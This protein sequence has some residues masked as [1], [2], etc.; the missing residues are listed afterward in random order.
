[1]PIYLGDTRIDSLKMG[2]QNISAGYL[3][4]IQVF[5]ADAPAPPPTGDPSDLAGLLR[6]WDAGTGVTLSTSPADRVDQWDDQSGN[7]GHMTPISFNN[8]RPTWHTNQINGLPALRFLRSDQRRLTF[9]NLGSQ[10]AAEAFIV[11]KVDLDPPTDASASALWDIQAQVGSG[12]D[13]HY[14]FTDSNVYDTFGTTARKS[15]GNPATNLAGWHLYNVRTAS[16]AW[17][18]HINGTQH[19]T[20]ATNTVGFGTAAHYLG[21]SKNGNYWLSG[22][23]AELFIYN[24]V[25]GASERD[26]V[27]TYLAGKYGL[28]IA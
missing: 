16:G 18:S 23:V 10:T 8:T 21:Q 4:T 28:T 7:A 9:A 13:T 19:F 5:G 22:Y 14:P 12:A 27:H 24:R 15:T 1:M 26:D 25:L 3:G 6:W 17:S 20:T 2:G 11:V